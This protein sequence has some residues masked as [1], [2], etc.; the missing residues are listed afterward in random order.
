[1]EI[2]IEPLIINENII[3]VMFNYDVSFIKNLKLQ[4]KTIKL[5][6][7]QFLDLSN[8]TDINFILSDFTKKCFNKNLTYNIIYNYYVNYYTVY[9]KPYTSLQKK[10]IYYSKKITHFMNNINN[11]NKTITDEIINAFDI[12]NSLIQ[13]QNI[14]SDVL[15]INHIYENL[16]ENIPYYKNYNEVMEQIADIKNINSNITFLYFLSNYESFI[17][18]EYLTKLFWNL[19]ELDIIHKQHIFYIYVYELKR[20]IIN[21]LNNID[22]RK[23]I[24]YEIDTEE[25]L[26]HIKIGKLNNTSMLKIINKII[27]ILNK[28]HFEIKY[29]KIHN[30]DIDV[31]KSIYDIINV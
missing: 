28:N 20:Q 2:I 25:I 27:K 19:F 23:H 31:Y 11:E 8:D 5:K 13:L 24:F 14:K 17:E 1:M 30:I 26:N 22:E 6:K 4:N 18:N 7:E 21:K 3:D 10:L 15:K 16:I 29:N 12:T 9:D